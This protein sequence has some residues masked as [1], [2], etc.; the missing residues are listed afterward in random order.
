VIEVVSLSDADSE[1]LI[2][3]TEKLVSYWKAVVHGRPGTPGLKVI[4]EYDECERPQL[5]SIVQR[6]GKNHDPPDSWLL[7]RDT[8][9]TMAR[10][11]SGLSIGPL[12][13]YVQSGLLSI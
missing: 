13:R 9:P 10:V 11:I 8:E 2:T 7:H 3:T 4:A 6:S 12:F 5:E 1:E